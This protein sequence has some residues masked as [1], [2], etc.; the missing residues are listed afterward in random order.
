MIKKSPEYF[1]Q[2]REKRNELKEFLPEDLKLIYGH[3][4][5]PVK[6][7]FKGELLKRR[8][9][10]EESDKLFFKALKNYNNNNKEIDE[11]L[12]EEKKGSKKK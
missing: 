1:S 6:W 7:S 8:H 9:S 4:I 10:E 2:K 5:K 3:D 11:K 12:L